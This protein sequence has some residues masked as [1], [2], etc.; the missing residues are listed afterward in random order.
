MIIYYFLKYQTERK[1]K[2]KKSPWFQKER[3]LTATLLARR[4]RTSMADPRIGAKRRPT[5]RG[6]AAGVVGPLPGLSEGPGA[7]Q[8]APEAW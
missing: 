3:L 7:S 2:R 1:N 4:G 8:E 5:L 6:T